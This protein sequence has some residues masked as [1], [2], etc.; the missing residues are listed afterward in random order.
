MGQVEVS[1]GDTSAVL[2][3]LPRRSDLPVRVLAQDPDKKKQGPP[4]ILLDARRH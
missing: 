2:G 4:K 3:E 1:A